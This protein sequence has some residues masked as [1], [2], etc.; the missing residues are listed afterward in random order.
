SI[1]RN[2]RDTVF[3]FMI[4]EKDTAYGRIKRCEGFDAEVQK[5]KKVNK[6]AYPV[7]MELKK[8][9]GH[10]GLPDRDKIKEMSAHRRNVGPKRVTW[11]LSGGPIDRFFW[12]RVPK[13]EAGAV[14]D[15]AIDGQTITVSATKV[16]RVELALDARLVSFDKPLS[17]VVNGKKQAVKAAPSLLTL[18]R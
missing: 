7:T 2:L 11:E 9:M 8:G 13:A 10:G 6:G 5:L 15:A 4:G 18:C 1:A 12:L 17:V 3:T 14:I 16:S